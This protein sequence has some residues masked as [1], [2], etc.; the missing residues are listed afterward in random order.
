MKIVNVEPE[1]VNEIIDALKPW[2]SIIIQ[3]TDRKNNKIVVTIEED[4][5]NL[6][7][8]EEEPFYMR[9]GSGLD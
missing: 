5:A 2:E 3:K 4:T 8:L 7:G 6:L 9:D 1:E